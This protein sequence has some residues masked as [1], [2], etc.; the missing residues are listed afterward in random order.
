MDFGAIIGN[1]LRAAIGPEA[2]IFALAAIGLNLHYGYTGLLNFG[3]VGFM[4]MGTYGT[5][6]SV[7]TW[8]LPLWLGVLIGLGAAVLLALA[9]GLPTLRLRADYF[10]ITTIAAAEILRFV[11]RSSSATD[12]TG[13]PF[14]LQGVA[15]DF[16]DLNVIPDGRYGTGT[17]VFSARTLW[18]MLV[19]WVL[20]ALVTLILA[21]LVRSPW[22]RVITSIREDE[23]VARS[24]GKNVFSYKM[25]ALVFGGVIGGLAGVMLA[26][27]TS[28]ANANSFLPTVTFFAY[29]ILFLGGAATRVGPIIG[30]A[31]FWF[32]YGGSDSLL[33][34]MASNDLLPDLLTSSGSI[35]AIRLV[36]VGLMLMALM[37]FR[38]QGIFG[39]KRQMVLDA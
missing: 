6:V 1:C 3:Q 38:P 27:S 20:V 28:A 14:G 35:G 4:L 18:V 34:E 26:M 10:A 13:G 31:I 24:L 9:M 33:R 25:Q 23:D 17:F 11:V 16:Y 32:V 15:G 12:V 30:A 2:A 36:L 7:V 29:T 22:G 39:D 19:A 8:D 5:A 37:I 21:R